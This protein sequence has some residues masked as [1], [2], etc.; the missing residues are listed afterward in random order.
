MPDE[1]TAKATAL[2]ISKFSDLINKLAGPLAEEFGLMLG[3]KVRVYRVKN[4]IKTVE[5]TERLLREAR[6]SAHAVPP[7]L[8]LPIMEASSVEDNETL[9]DMWAGLLA[10]ASQDTDAVS[11]SFVETLKQLTPDEARYLHRLH[12][13]AL[14]EKRQRHPDDDGWKKVLERHPELSGWDKSVANSRI[15]L[16]AFPPGVQRKS[17]EKP[18]SDTYERLGLIRREYGLTKESEG[19]DIGIAF[20]FTR[21]ANKFIQACQ[22]P[23]A[24][25][26]E[27]DATT[28]NRTSS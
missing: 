14:K 9:Q 19:Q 26:S 1:E 25:G 12:N 8:L 15:S 5:K 10:T 13:D 23:S 28:Q 11:P 16:T 6:L 3:D 7:R 17:E 2:A 27:S 18:S 22:G 4:W 21:Y 24:A 20:R